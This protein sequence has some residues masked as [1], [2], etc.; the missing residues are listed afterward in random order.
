MKDIFG[1]TDLAKGFNKTNKETAKAFNKTKKEDTK[2]IKQLFTT[3]VQIKSFIAKEGRV[4]IP[5]KTRHV[6]WARYKNKCAECSKTKPL[7]IHHKNGKNDDPRPSNLILLCANHHMEI[8]A[9][10]SELNK[11]IRQRS[12]RK[13]S[14]P[15]SF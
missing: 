15:F 11:K 4:P 10:G 12:K 9:K 13:S 2:K 14:S 8:H 3:R 7:Q 6:I 1:N 5:A